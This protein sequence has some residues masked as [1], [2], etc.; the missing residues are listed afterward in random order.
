MMS[1]K[2]LDRASGIKNFTFKQFFKADWGEERELPK[3][4]DKSFN[5]MWRE[6]KGTK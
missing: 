6:L 4:E 3:I 1:R 5:Q 2:N